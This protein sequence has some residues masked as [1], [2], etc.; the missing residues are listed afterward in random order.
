M[1]RNWSRYQSDLRAFAR[2]LRYDPPASGPENDLFLACE[3]REPR[4]G[5]VDADP[6]AIAAVMIWRALC[7]P[8]DS[9]MVV[10]SCKAV[11]QGHIEL[12]ETL[13]SE[14]HEA[15]RSEVWLMKDQTGLIRPNCT[16][17]AVVICRPQVLDWEPLNDAKMGN[18]LI[19]I[20][21]IDEIPG[22]YLRSAADLSQKA[23]IS[24]AFNVAK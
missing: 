14:G 1:A 11:G 4:I 24:V 20:P 3:K 23:N 5:V 15:V 19:L 21:D 12:C 8:E 2:L 9:T 22:C 16:R 6:K 17:P 18:L 13:L 10:N 7:F